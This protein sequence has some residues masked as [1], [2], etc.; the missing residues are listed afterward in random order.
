MTRIAIAIETDG[1]NWVGGQ[2]VEISMHELNDKLEVVRSFSGVLP[3]KVTEKNF[4]YLD[5]FGLLS[6]RPT[7]TKSDVSAWL[8]GYENIGWVKDKGRSV[9]TFAYRWMQ[10]YFRYD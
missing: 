5:R 3:F 9:A 6:L 2:V 8:E 4:A 10:E 7:C 1:T